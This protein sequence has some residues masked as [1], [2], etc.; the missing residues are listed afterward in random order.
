MKAVL[1]SL[2]ALAILGPA[3]APSEAEARTCRTNRAYHVSNKCRCPR[4]SIRIRPSQ[5]QF[6]CVTKPK[7]K[8]CR[9]NRRYHVSNKCRC[10]LRTW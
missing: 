7:R 5:S 1:S 4:Y 9:T 2:F 3:F 6:M 10:M 8:T